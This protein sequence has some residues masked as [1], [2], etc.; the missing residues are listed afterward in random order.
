MT[1]KF[2]VIV[3]TLNSYQLL[4]KLTQSLQSQTFRDWRCLFI[5]GPSSKEHRQWLINCCQADPRFQWSEQKPQHQKIFGAMNQGFQEA[6]PQEWILFWGSD[7]WATSSTVLQRLAEAIPT[8]DQDTSTDLVI[9]KGR[10]ANA[11][12]QLSRRTAFSS[13][14]A[15]IDLDATSFRR[16]LFLGQTPPH[17]GTLFSPSVQ[18]KL[19]QYD[20]RYSLAADL[21][22]FLRLSNQKALNIRCIDLELIH[23]SEGGVSGQHTKSRFNQVKT[24]Y[25]QTFGN[26]WWVPFTSRYIRRLASALKR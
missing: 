2:L 18:R 26:L 8:Q 10:Y 13:K 25:Q 24:S 17:Q 3:P 21:D 20:E 4:P 19:N 6:K 1:I 16:K 14:G 15:F 5:D 12:G 7:D 23:M 9:A 22:Y 11:Q